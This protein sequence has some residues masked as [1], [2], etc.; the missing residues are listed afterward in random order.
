MI[1]PTLGVPVDDR[2]EVDYLGGVLEQLEP[3]LEVKRRSRSFGD[4][5]RRSILRLS[6]PPGTEI[7][8][9]AGKATFQF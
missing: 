1:C 7:N 8:L 9:T 4:P 6:L 2:D 5:N 3:T